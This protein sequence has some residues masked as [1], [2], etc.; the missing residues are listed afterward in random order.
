ME[1]IY[2]RHQDEELVADSPGWQIH[3]AIAP[4]PGDMIFDKH[5][6]SAFKDTG[7]QAYLDKQ[8]IDRLILMG[9]ATNFC[10]DTTIKVAFE[11]GYQLAVIKDGTSTSDCGELSARSLV[12]YHE[13]IWDG[14]FAQVDTLENILRG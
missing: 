12:D 6:N 4:M 3:D 5:Y 2:V 9:M 1:I 10:V 11:L 13:T 8:G 7:L 14:R